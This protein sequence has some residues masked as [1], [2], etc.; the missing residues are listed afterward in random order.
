MVGYLGQYEL[1]ASRALAAL[2]EGTLVSVRLADFNAGTLDDFQV[3]AADSVDAYQVKWSLLPRSV[4]YAD[5]VHDAEGRTRYIRQ[6]ADGWERL[7]ALHHPRRV[8]AHFV[9]ND[10]PST[11]TS[12]AIPRAGSAARA[13]GSGRAWSFAV[14]LAEAWYPAVDA[15]RAGA[16]PSDAVPASW[17]PAMS[18]FA[19]AS[20]LDAEAWQR[21][22]ADCELEFGVPG[23]EASV[24]SAPVTAAERVVLRKDTHLLAQAFARLV[25]RPDRR[26][27][28]TREQLLDEVGWRYRAE[29][30]HTHEFPDP[31]I[32]YRSIAA[33]AHD[34]TTAIEQFTGGY[35]AVTGSPGSGKSTLLSRTLRENPHRVVRYYAFIPDA[36]GGS[37]RR[38][39]AVNFFHDLTVALDRAGLRAG[40]TLPPDDLD[41]LV[42]RVHSQLSLAHEEWAAGG[43]RTI[44]LVDGLDHIPREQR[45]TQSLLSHLPHPEDIPDGVLFVL[46]TQTD[47]LQPISPRIRDQLDEP[48]RRV[49]MR[50]LER[51]DVFGIVESSALVP[52]PTST[53][54]QR[55][56]ELSAGHPL[57]LNYIINRLRHAS[58]APIADTLD[59]V[60]PF[61]DGID[62]QYATI[63]GTVEDDAEL[64][65]LLAL[66]ARARGP[67]RLDWV[68]RWALRQA[69]HT[70]TTRLAYLFRP[71]HGGRWAFFHNSFRAFL[72]ERTRGFPALGREAELFAELAEHC[73][74]ADARE[75]EHADELY[76][77]AR[78][79][80][81][82]RVLALAD[83]ETLRA[84][85]VAGRSAT[86]IRDDLEFALDAAVR[87]R[88]VIALTRVL[89]CSAEFV[90]REYYAELLPLAETWL[91]LGD[92]DLALGA[93]REGS[94]L[95]TSRETAL[96]AAA[97]LDERGFGAEARDVFMIAEPLDVLGGFAERTGR[98]RA[99]IDVLDAWVAVAPRFRALPEVLDMIQ[100][101]RA[102]AEDYWPRE[103]HERAE[104]DQAETK[105]RQSR[106]LQRL[107]MAL[108][109]LARYEDA[110]AVREA[111]LAR[112]DDGRWWFWT[113]SAA[114]GDALAADEQLRAEVRFSVLRERIERGE[115][116]EATLGPSERVA[117]AAGYVRITHD[118]R[119]ATRALEGVEQ[120]AAV[121]S[122]M[123][124]E[125]DG[126][127][128]FYQRFALNRVLGALGDRSSL[129]EIV[130][131]VPPAGIGRSSYGDEGSALVARFERG[132]VLLGRLAGRAWV[133]D[134]L[135]PTDFVAHARPLIHLFPDHP[136]LV[137]GGYIAIRAREEL[138]K[139]LVRVAALHGEDCVTAL[140]QQLETEWS[141]E[142]RRD[143]W[144]DSLVRT[145]LTESLGVGATAEWV[146][147]WLARIEPTTFRGEDL[148]SDLPDGI[149][150]ARAWVAAGDV[151][152]AR[153]TL[154]RVLRAAFGNEVKDDQ[155]SACLAWAA[156]ANSEDPSRM[157]DRLAL[158]AAAVRSLDGAEAERYVAPEL[159]DAG[160]AGGARPARA[161]VEWALR[162]DV[163]NW[164]GAMTV[165]M[166][167]LATRAP[168]AAAVLSTCYRLLVL[169]FART[170]DV[171]AVVHLAAALRAAGETLEF[172]ALAE[173][174][175]V[176]ALGSKRPALREAVAGR[177]TEAEELLR[178]NGVTDP[179]A[180]NQ[181][182]DAFEGLSL[183]LRELQVRV[184]SVA[185]VEDLVRRLK[186][187][188]FMYRWE[189][190]LA[191]F[192]GRATAD[193]L[194][195]TAA[196]I[197][198]NDY[199]WRVLAAI[200][201]RLLDLGDVRAGTVVSRV[202]RSSRAAGWSTRFDD[203]S[204]LAAFELLVRVAPRD[205][206]DA[207]WETL[208]SDIAAG[209]VRAIDVF[210][211][212]NRVVAMLAPDTSAVDIWEVVSLHVAALVAYAPRGAPLEL[213]AAEDPED[214]TAA[215]EAVCGLVATYLDHPAYALAQGA[216]RFFTD[217][218]L[219]RDH[220]AEA[221]L[222]AR[223]VTD[224]TPKNGA[225]LVLR[226]VAR[227][228]GDVPEAVR[229]ALRPLWHAPQYPDRRAAVALMGR[230]EGDAATGGATATAIQRPLPS[231]FQLV[232]PPAPP[233]VE[234]RLPGPGEMLAPAQ[235]AADLV[236]VFR[237]ELDLIARWA[238]V[239][240]EAL[241][242]YVADRALADLPAGSRDYTFDE[243]P[244]LR[245]EMQRLGLEIT[246]R[247]PRPRRVERAM[248]EATAMLVDHGRIA[249]RYL[250][251]L[252]RLFRSADPHFLVARPSRR[253][254][255]IAS[256]PERADSNYVNSDWTAAVT[257][258]DAV[259]GRAMWEPS[260]EQP[261]VQEGAL[262][263]QEPAA[264]HDASGA[265][266]SADPND[267]GWIVLAEETWLRWLDWQYATET[268]VGARL[269]PRI[270]TSINP[271][272]DTDEAPG[273]SD[274]NGH[275]AA[276]RALNAHVAGHSHL[277]ADEYLEHGGA[278]YSIVVRNDT[279]RF[280]TPG[281]PWLAFN[282]ALAE[283]IGW[284]PAQD[285]LF[286]WLDQSGKVVA[287]SV[288]W[289]DG[290]AQQRPPLFDD[291]VGHGWLVRVSVGG[292]RQLATSIGQCVDWRRVA[293]H[294]RDRP[295]REKVAWEPVQDDLPSVSD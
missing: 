95:R 186:P 107:A 33:T 258:N 137:R 114:C 50:S 265:R 110:D 208:R 117:L 246:Y 181:V 250:P 61:R 101:L 166:D 230:D 23:L 209:E 286:R 27:E 52:P 219:A 64:A 85:F 99:E 125:D 244:D 190:I 198:Q 185:E 260:A 124:G 82:A 253:P 158:M 236:S 267:D 71:E 210:R 282:P 205:D 237:A 224:D 146:R 167:G 161:L 163:E 22:V 138:Y 132:V 140:Q 88:D 234:R 20:G 19:D 104:A 25:T 152:A 10:L 38:G 211:V 294:A 18:A 174:I 216:Q 204:R 81:F 109:G 65:R 271:E 26:V 221:A 279:Y 225:L 41:L 249:E 28:F 291:E 290:F 259:T 251:A 97:A 285:G 242:R 59:A 36:V 180:P 134:H 139:W 278:P 46:G 54:L 133:E 56:F 172:D 58:G 256:I 17:A 255:L 74:A 154:E 165:F 222:N 35:L 218:L 240:K 274:I 63:W 1:A 121:D 283:H 106:L 60:E 228:R 156:R 3:L 173:A 176:V 39:E 80:D 195:A 115:I 170:A 126:W 118:L 159:L 292:W 223:L 48:G 187:N 128:P 227:V 149:S 51:G 281:G 194:V 207:A 144:P 280:E 231:A 257:A 213:P 202:L 136:Q 112:D 93:L 277:M 42:R 215:A 276:G 2:R 11:G 275:T 5:F 239:Q 197:P 12:Q 44:I 21:F 37:L 289:Q 145:L 162:N 229:E 77:R 295:P 293:R 40:T 34:L 169:P 127:G 177:A 263:S 241:Y 31:T 155:L 6:L 43:R 214:P 153:T 203:G 179:T 66:L 55:I 113:Q 84:Q 24:E 15:A 108:D 235:I 269:E 193:E 32:P 273:S 105:S 175:E 94:S 4:G 188:A 57:A 270:R 96:R 68:R 164:V 70:V 47:R 178:D 217:R 102:S 206:R 120:P 129:H 264:W 13:E 151:I 147:T 247:R 262:Q 100:R 148:Q 73:A 248:A 69:L 183:T 122:T 78:A 287:E 86:T 14:F 288:W 119:A 135:A 89:L 116:P 29:F 8:V 232:Y 191:P 238:G 123:L 76:Y 266:G 91:E 245:T 243:E 98:P 30:R 261:A 184:R 201:E 226:A 212:W 62:R 141:D 72:I 157:P 150:Q 131:D 254:G 142:T 130:P 92:V 182:V 45:P 272:E 168:A 268:R 196:A 103:E 233:P 220:V 87:E 143:A 189:L 160:V 252:D 200:A 83:P 9:T 53:E 90:Q 79:G 199:A 171:E 284:R 111:L 67:V 49:T 192:L 75:P 16:D 7:S